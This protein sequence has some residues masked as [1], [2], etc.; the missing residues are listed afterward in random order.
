LVITRANV[1]AASANAPSLSGARTRFAWCVGALAVTR[2]KVFEP[3]VEKSGTCCHPL[4][5]AAGGA[6]QAAEACHS[7]LH[8]FAGQQT[9]DQWRLLKPDSFL[10]KFLKKNVDI[11][12]CVQ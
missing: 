7:H 9:P 6:M 8:S 3:P 5:S 1:V 12:W 4:D 2:T 10:K 11:F